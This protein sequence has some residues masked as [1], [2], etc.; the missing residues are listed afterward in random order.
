MQETLQRPAD[1]RVL[2][3]DDNATH[4]QF[5]RCLFESL[6]CRVWTVANGLEAARLA[7]AGAFDI[8]VLDRRMPV[9]DGDTAAKAI[10]ERDV[11]AQ[12]LLVSHSSEP[13]RGRAAALYDLVIPKPAR[14]VDV[15]HLVAARRRH[16]R[17]L[18]A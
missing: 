4:R 2:I 11:L 1:P 7:E 12:M 9:C 3:A 6:G 15:V 17:A 18:A 5:G 13:P 8:V 16:L 14:V 10:R